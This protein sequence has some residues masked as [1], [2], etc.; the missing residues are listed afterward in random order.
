MR[1][2][3][4]RSDILFIAGC[5]IVGVLFWFIQDQ[6]RAT[7]AM[8]RIQIDGQEYGTYS[9]KE[10]RKIPIEI[11][12][13]QTNQVTIQNEAATMTEA[14][15]PDHLC[16]H[17]RSIRKVNESIVCL[18]NKVVVTVIDPNAEETDIDVIAK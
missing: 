14:D 6:Q 7:G 13:R 16:M 10:D 2:R 9:L 12:G 17:Q 3:I 11:N 8:I 4:G 1:K 18:P 15:C 5:L